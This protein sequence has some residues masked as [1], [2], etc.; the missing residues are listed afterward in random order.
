VIINFELSAR[1]WSVKHARR[2]IIHSGRVP[3]WDGHIHRPIDG[4][5]VKYI[6]MKGCYAEAAV[7]KATN[8]PGVKAHCGPYESLVIQ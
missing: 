8:K 4:I 3:E 7:D 6:Y 5:I 1:N 2:G